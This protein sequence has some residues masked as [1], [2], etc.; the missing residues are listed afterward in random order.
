MHPPVRKRASSFFSL[1]EYCLQNKEK[2]LKPSLRGNFSVT[3]SETPEKSFD[4]VDALSHHKVCRA[5][6]NTY[7]LG[8]QMLFRPSEVEVILKNELAFLVNTDYDP[9]KARIM[10]TDLANAIRSQVKPLYPRYKFVVQ[11]TIGGKEHQGVKVASNFFWDVER[12][13]FASY[14]VTNRNLFA[15]ATVYGIYYD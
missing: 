14:T 11:V 13:N 10:A 7:Q 9:E 3:H 1:E 4:A 15:V 5:I 8:P 12:D 2:Y 6:R